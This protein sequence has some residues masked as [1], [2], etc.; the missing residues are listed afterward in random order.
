M[1]VVMF[2]V[3]IIYINTIILMSFPIH[4]FTVR[5][6]ESVC[7]GQTPISSSERGF[8]CKGIVPKYFLWPQIL[9]SPQTTSCCQPQCFLSWRITSATS[10]PPT[11]F[12]SQCL[13]LPLPLSSSF[14]TFS[15]ELIYGF[16]LTTPGL[17]PFH[18]HPYSS[19][20]FFLHVSLSISPAFLFLFFFL[21]FQILSFCLKCPHLLSANLGKVHAEL[22][23]ESK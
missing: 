11:S 9:D 6:G 14:K 22:Q 5:E 1:N 19:T 15:P 16:L 10:H 8:Y 3:M 7:V 4:V 20:T 13:H 12:L 23:I 2:T 21:F 17:Q 18:F